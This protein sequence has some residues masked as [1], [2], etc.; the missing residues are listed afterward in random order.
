[1][2]CLQCKSSY[3]VLS[4]YFYGSLILVASSQSLGWVECICPKHKNYCCFVRLWFLQ[5]CI[6]KHWM[7]C[8]SFTSGPN[9]HPFLTFPLLYFRTKYCC[10]RAFKF[11]VFKTPRSTHCIWSHGVWHMSRFWCMLYASFLTL[12]WTVSRDCFVKL[13]VCISVHSFQIYKKPVDFHHL[14]VQLKVSFKYGR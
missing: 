5:G 10:V 12:C 11:G 13:K 14:V 7:I 6:L 8:L 9:C 3:L 4:G 1:M 2:S